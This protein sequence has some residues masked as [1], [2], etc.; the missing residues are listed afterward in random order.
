MALST[1]QGFIGS[2]DLLMAPYALSVLGK[3]VDVGNATEFAIKPNSTR[4]DQRSKKRGQRGQIL[5]SVSLMEPSEVT[6]T[7]ETLRLG[8]LRY[9]FMGEDTAYAQVGAT[10]TDA[11]TVAKLD[12]WVQ[13]PAEDL[14]A[15]VLKKGAT[16]LTLGATYEVNLRLGMYKVLSTNAQAVVEDD[17]LLVSYTSGSF[18]GAAIRGA[19]EPQVR[20][21]L[22]LDGQ[23]DVDGSIGVLRCW[24]ALLAPTEPFDWYKDTFN[25]IKL[26][27]TLKTPVGRTEPFRFYAR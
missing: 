12:G 2:G 1:A 27:G 26:A 16:T 22:L 19:V 4:Q 5:E 14:S 10:V 23:N 6:I 24:E 9:A 15:F 20:A 25:T 18:T 3:L 13:L 11:A 21:F 8:N 7:I 17:A